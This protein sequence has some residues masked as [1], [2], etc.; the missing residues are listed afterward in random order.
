M[1]FTHFCRHPDNQTQLRWGYATLVITDG[2]ER[3]GESR[4]RVGQGGRVGHRGRPI[5]RATPYWRLNIALCGLYL[6]YGCEGQGCG[7]MFSMRRTSGGRAEAYR[8]YQETGHKSGRVRHTYGQFLPG[9]KGGCRVPLSGMSC[10]QITR[11]ACGDVLLT[12]MQAAFTEPC[13][14]FR[15]VRRLMRREALASSPTHAGRQADT[16]T[17][18]VTYVSCRG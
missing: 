5:L 14:R 17:D 16:D 3:V 10:W 18:S 4:E 11:D 13:F 2:W 9:Y 7:S 12:W 1:A 8:R 6:Q 15:Q